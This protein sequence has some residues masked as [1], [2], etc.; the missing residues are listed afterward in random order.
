MTCSF[1]IILPSVKDLLDVR[2]QL[3]RLRIDDLEFL[4]DA[5]G[6]DMLIHAA[7][8]RV[9]SIYTQAPPQMERFA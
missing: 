7:N 6:E 4:L 9:I 1:K 8:R 2:T 5:E 3:A